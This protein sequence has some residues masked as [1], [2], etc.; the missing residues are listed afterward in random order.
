MGEGPHERGALVR[1]EGSMDV[2]H[3]GIGERAGGR[4]DQ[5]KALRQEAGRA[6]GPQGG[7]ER[8]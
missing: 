6:D 2:S 4:K 3:A 7:P 5:A 1:P 8:L